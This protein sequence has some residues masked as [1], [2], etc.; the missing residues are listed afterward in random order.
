MEDDCAE[1]E[2]E[3]V[4]R[5]Q[6]LIYEKTYSFLITLEEQRDLAEIFAIRTMVAAEKHYEYSKTTESVAI[7]AKAK[8]NI[9][10][11]NIMNGENR[12]EIIKGIKITTEVEKLLKNEIE[13]KALD[14][15][16][17]ML[18]T[19]YFYRAQL[20]RHLNK[21]MALR[22]LKKTVELAKGLEAEATFQ[23][24]VEYLLSLM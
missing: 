10:L 1:E 18:A 9:A 7:Y 19:T 13:N 23:K 16:K 20:Y 4:F 24:K 12:R 6:Y 2:K 17:H 5:Y 11:C 8:L 22:L 3:M 15:Y 21:R 14:I